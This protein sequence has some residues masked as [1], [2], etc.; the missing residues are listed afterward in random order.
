VAASVSQTGLLVTRSG[1]AFEPTR[2]TWFDRKGARLGT[3]GE[4]G[5][6]RGVDLSPNGQFVAYHLHQEPGG[7][8]IW[9]QDL[10]RGN[11]IRYTFS[12]HNFSP[13][14]SRDGKYVMFT[15]DR[16]G[17][18]NLYRK[19]AGGATGDE[20]MLGSGVAAF[21]EDVTPDGEWMVYGGQTKTGFDVLRVPLNRKGD[22][23]TI[24]SSP[25]FDGLSKIS[26]DG[27]WIAWE[28]DEGGRR[29]VFAQPFPKATSKFQISTDGGRYVRWSATG[30]EIFYLKDDGTLMSASV[31]VE[32]DALVAST[33][34]TLFKTD[35]IISNHRGSGLDL[36]YDV[37]N[38]GQRFIVNERVAPTSQQSPISVVVNW[39]SLLKK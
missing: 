20:M 36:P 27:K 7:G 12:G 35:P 14:W 22:P 18:A 39:T 24:V 16:D 26:P 3:I 15:S 21:V 17:G 13:S 5:L 28:S 25:F 38:D 2:L 10:Q 6:Y 9:V 32:G 34:K 8:D 29:Q 23:E 1:A 37:T 11:S 31:R 19:A 4:V 33:P 30:N